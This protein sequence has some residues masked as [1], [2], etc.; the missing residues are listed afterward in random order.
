MVQQQYLY[1]SRESCPGLSALSVVGLALPCTDAL[2]I[3]PKLQSNG[4]Y[5]GSWPKHERMWPMETRPWNVLALD[6]PTE[7]LSY[8][9]QISFPVHYYRQKQDHSDCTVPVH[10]FTLGS[11]SSFDHTTTTS[12]NNHM[13]NTTTTTETSLGSGLPQCSH[14]HP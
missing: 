7:Y 3:M 6:P 8:K 13:H 1:R 14:D 11:P 4:L 9:F 10:R 2:S 12:N 5:H